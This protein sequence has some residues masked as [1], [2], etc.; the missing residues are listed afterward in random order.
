[1]SFEQLQNEFPTFYGLVQ[2]GRCYFT[3]DSV[4]PGAT[5]AEIHEIEQKIGI[6]LPASYKRFLRCC[7]GFSLSGIGVRFNRYPVFYDFPD[8]LSSPSQGM[9]CFA[10]FFMEADG[11]V[12][13]FDVAA[14]LQDDEDEKRIDT[15]GDYGISL[16]I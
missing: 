15:D 1:M 2:E 12:V 7:R 3:L 8:D 16:T 10:D 13:L 9:L 5:D 11:D 6:P 14:G 4:L